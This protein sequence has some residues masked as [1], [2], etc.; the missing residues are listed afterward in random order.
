M[1]LRYENSHNKAKEDKKQP[2]WNQ[3]EE[4]KVMGVVVKVTSKGKKPA[5]VENQVEVVG[6][7]ENSPQT[8]ASGPAEE[9]EV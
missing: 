5:E 9:D 1:T 7:I 2:E 6:T 8:S 4:E 3:D